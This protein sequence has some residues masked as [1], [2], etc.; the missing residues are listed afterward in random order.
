MRVGIALSLLSLLAC[1]S[2]AP[3][4][5]PD[6][7]AARV[8]TLQSRLD[9][10]NTRW[11]ASRACADQC[12]VSHETCSAA[13]QLCGLAASRSKQA[14]VQRSCSI[15]WDDCETREGSCRVCRGVAALEA[16]AERLLALH[17]APDADRGACNP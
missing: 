9:A 2:S 15:G 3:T 1:A 17:A 12:R 7:E 13:R 5:E 11:L 8:A 6:R 10:L 14:D 16:P 4:R